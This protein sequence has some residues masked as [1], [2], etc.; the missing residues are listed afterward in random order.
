MSART[1]LERS[2]FQ[3]S[4]ATP[5]TC[6]L[7]G[8]PDLVSSHQWISIQRPFTGAVTRHDGKLSYQDV[9]DVT[10]IVL[11]EKTAAPKEE[12]TKP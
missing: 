2:G 4:W 12:H 1:G 11:T 5:R 10:E 3:T 6:I 9:R 8:A 7:D